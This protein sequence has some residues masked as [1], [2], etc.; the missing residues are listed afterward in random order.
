MS[1]YMDK[2]YPSLRVAF[3]RVHGKTPIAVVIKPEYTYGISDETAIRVQQ[4]VDS[5]S[6]AW[7]AIQT[8]MDT[9]K[10]PVINGHAP[11]SVEFHKTV[12]ATKCQV[13]ALAKCPHVKFV[14]LAAA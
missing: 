1:A 9:H 7:A 6:T 2:T 14:E 10:I 13:E 4:T 12:R 5:L 3:K 11:Q 8:V